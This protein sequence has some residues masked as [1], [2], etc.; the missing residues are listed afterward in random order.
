MLC[1]MSD[2]HCDPVYTLYCD[3]N[4]MN[5]KMSNKSRIVPI[6]QGKLNQGVKD[7]L[8]SLIERNG[9]LFFFTSMIVFCFFEGE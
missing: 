6:K 3:I 5:S 1:M 4:R 9:R 8:Y 2:A 7:L